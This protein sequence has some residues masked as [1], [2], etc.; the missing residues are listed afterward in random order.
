MTA[1]RSLRVGD[2]VIRY[3]VARSPRRR[4][5][6]T[7][8]LRPGGL[9]EV[10]APMRT[11]NREIEDL[12][13][14]RADWI[15]RKLGEQRPAPVARQF[16]PGESLPYMGSAVPIIVRPSPLPLVSVKL[17]NGAFLVKCPE[18]LTGEERRGALRE[19]FKRWYK[20]RA[21]EELGVL[22]ER[23]QSKV[24]VKPARISIGDQKT[25]WG[26][27]SSKGSLRFNLRL[28]MAPRELIEYVT[29]HELCHMLVPN[30]SPKFWE[31]VG[32]VMPDYEE[33]RRRLRELEPT[34]SL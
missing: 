11:R 33:R 3:S 26:S 14:K 2:D 6:I 30:H 24:G 17:E 4:K 20:A 29:V 10:A 9:V 7:I 16:E 31:E 8:T 22:V 5:T 21:Y 34:L 15:I 1:L 13:R 32:R 12:V 19:M 28:A 23:W 25:R 27:C 18:T